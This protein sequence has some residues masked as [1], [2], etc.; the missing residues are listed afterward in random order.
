[1]KL[2]DLVVIML[3]KETISVSKNE[4]DTR[5]TFDDMELLVQYGGKYFYTLMIFSPFLSTLTNHC[6]VNGFRDEI[7]ME[8]IRP[9]VERYEPLENLYRDY[10]N[11]NKDLGDRVRYVMNMEV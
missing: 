7:F 1:M 5:L 3:L 8:S 10:T 2:L 9:V 11:K 6:I 4:T